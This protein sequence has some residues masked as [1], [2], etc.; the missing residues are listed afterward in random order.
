MIDPFSFLEN[1]SCE[2]TPF[3]G[4]GGGLLGKT[5]MTNSNNPVGVLKSP[6]YISIKD[7]DDVARGSETACR[8]ALMRW[9]NEKT[10]AVDLALAEDIYQERLGIPGRVSLDTIPLSIF[11]EFQERRLAYRN[12][13]LL[14]F[15]QEAFESY[16]RS[17]H[18]MSH[19]MF[20]K[21][22][23]PSWWTDSHGEQHSSHWSFSRLLTR[24]HGAYNKKLVR[25]F[26]TL[27]DRYDGVCCVLVVLTVDPGFFGG[28][29]YRMWKETPA[30]LNRFL[31]DLRMTFSRM[32]RA[33]PPYLLTPES[34]KDAA[35]EGNPHFNL[36][37]FG[38]SRL[39]DWR[40][41]TA[42]WGIGNI[43]INRTKD[44]GSVRHP[45]RYVTKYVTKC[46]G[47]MT[48]D[49]VQLQSLLWLFGR[50]S[51]SCSRG[52]IEPLHDAATGLW[53]AISYCSLAPRALVVDEVDALEHRLWELGLIGGDLPPPLEEVVYG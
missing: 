5:L 49:N 29:K 13:S 38:C 26:K 53:S 36:L 4:E 34:H 1:P 18:S 8:L 33:M 31:S 40:R 11:D 27:A 12:A 50:R 15:A 23:N 17:V 52:L 45:V 9:E 37:F 2:K 32:G 14:S 39:M 7:A 25:R 28:D 30:H 41:L 16:Y 19:Y 24:Y 51:Y 22:K 44:G 43:Y 10:Y 6:D 35:S 21:E 42:L 46:F 20:L 47:A 3:E 48:A